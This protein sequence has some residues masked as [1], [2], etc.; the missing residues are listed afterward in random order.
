M[1]YIPFHLQLF[2][3]SLRSTKDNKQAETNK[4]RFL[5]IVV[6]GV[7]VRVAIIVLV[8]VVVAVIV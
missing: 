5:V 4:W 2:V 7:E 6:V 8:V 1:E 3:D